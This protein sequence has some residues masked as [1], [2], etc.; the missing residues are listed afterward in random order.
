[1]N[2]REEFE[3][4]RSTYVAAI[5]T[6]T[7]GTFGALIGAT[8]TPTPAV[9][10]TTT[11]FDHLKCFGV[12]DGLSGQLYTADLI[13]ENSI[14]ATENGDRVE[15][16]RLVKGCRIRVPALE[17]CS[18]VSKENA[19]NVR[20]GNPPPGASAGADAGQFMCYR[21]ICPNDRVK[22]QL[23]VTD[24]FGSRSITVSNRP[25]MLCAPIE[26]NVATPTPTPTGS[27]SPTGT[28]TP[29]GTPTVTATPTPVVTGT[30][31]ETPTPV[32]TATPTPTMGS[33]SGAFLDQPVF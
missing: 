1:M 18:A 2:S 3:M 22:P 24:Q 5:V 33:P 9:A 19:T 26:S 12:K 8:G 11:T 32:E 28:P 7:L 25:K 4:K 17:F 27:V 10:Q 30:P 15:G 23:N 29:S 21:L 16:G 13:P 20:S 31:V 6:V 14:L